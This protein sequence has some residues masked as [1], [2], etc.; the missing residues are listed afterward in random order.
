VTLTVTLTLTF[1]F[2]TLC[3][4]NTQLLQHQHQQQ[5]KRD[6]GEL[7]RFNERIQSLQQQQ[8]QSEAALEQAHAEIARLQDDNEAL[9]AAA[10]EQQQLQQQSSNSVS[11]CNSNGNVVQQVSP[12]QQVCNFKLLMFDKICAL[13]T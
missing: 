10:A 11:N 12:K 6:L 1:V 4:H 7:R 8:R 2:N 13:L 9:V 5:Q 3:Y